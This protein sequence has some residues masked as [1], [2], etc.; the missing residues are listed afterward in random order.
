MRYFVSSIAV[1]SFLMLGA[2]AA[3]Q[4]V[5][6]PLSGQVVLAGKSNVSGIYRFLGP[7]TIYVEGNSSAL[8]HAGGT[9]SAKL[10]ISD[11]LVSEVGTSNVRRT[12]D[13]KSVKASATV[14]VQAGQQYRIRLTSSNNNGDAVL[15][16]VSLTCK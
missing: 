6:C 8:L 10:Y 14:P 4:S 1:L 15:D 2:P 13:T 7:A 12:S 9:L 3:A 11:Q 5:S 16:Q